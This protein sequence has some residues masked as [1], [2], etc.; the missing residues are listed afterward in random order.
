MHQNTSQEVQ[1]QNTQILASD[2]I[3]EVSNKLHK[4]NIQKEI[5]VG[6]KPC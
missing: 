5:M 2:N 6:V 3:R 1:N 4:Q